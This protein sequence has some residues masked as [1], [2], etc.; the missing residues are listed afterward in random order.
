MGKPPMVKAMGLW[1]EY[2]GPKERTRGS[3][4]S[5][6]PEEKKTM[7]DSQSS[8]ERNGNSLNRCHASGTGVAGPR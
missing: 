4:T 7:S 8:G 3:E 5:Q 6:Y 2:I 1:P